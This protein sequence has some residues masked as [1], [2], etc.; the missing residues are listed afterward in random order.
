[1]GAGGRVF[2]LDPALGASPGHHAVVAGNYRRLLEGKREVRFVGHRG[3]AS[4]HPLF[5]HRLEDAFR[6][7]RYGV[8]W[9]GDRRLARLAQFAAGVRGRALPAAEGAGRAGAPLSD[10][11]YRALFAGL[12]AGAALDALQ[13]ELRADDDVV[14]LGVD[15][16]MLAAL[17]ARRLNAR[18]H[19]LFMYPDDEFLGPATQAA[20]W[21]LAS[22]VAA[23]AAGVYA[24]LAAHA[25]T[26]SGK[27]QRPVTVQTT[28]VRIAHVPAAQAQDFTVAVLGAGRWDKAFDLLP[29]IVAASLVRDPEVRFVIQAPA[30]NAGLNAPLKALCAMRGVAI[31][32]PVLDAA[33]YD[34]A[35]RD[36]AVVLLAYD[37]QRYQ[38]RGSGVLVDALIGGRPVIATEDTALANAMAPG[39]GLTGR[40]PESFAAAIAAM[41]ADYPR[42]LAAAN[43]EAAR[44][45]DILRDGPLLRALGAGA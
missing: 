23:D 4:E 15:P 44:R 12:D 32:P 22:E 20:Y 31:L 38:A 6:V 14:C 33:V 13:V 26:L 29:A 27:L 34:A 21:R 2:F 3:G 40:D 36:C 43:A 37:K 28:P 35:L 25:E 30:P 41:H 8:A 9:I 19:L 45:L 42:F 24:E 10:A 7:S 5:R 39:A 11:G 1:M 16:A 17:A 18:L